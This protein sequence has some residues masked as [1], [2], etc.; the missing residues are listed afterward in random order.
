[1]GVCEDTVKR[2]LGQPFEEMSIL[3]LMR[4]DPQIREIFLKPSQESRNSL[5]EDELM[6]VDSVPSSPEDGDVVVSGL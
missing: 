1:M 4:E 2:I 5:S 6:A 3:R